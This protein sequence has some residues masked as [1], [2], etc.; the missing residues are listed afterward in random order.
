MT[1]YL[2][3]IAMSLDGRIADR[4][5]GLA[6]LEAFGGGGEGDSDYE[7]FYNGVD[8]LVMGRT[9]YDVVAALGAWP[10]PGKR[11]FV[12]TG[13][14]LDAGRDEIVAIPADFPALKRRIESDGHAKV[15][16]VGGGRTQRAALDAGMFDTLR[17]FVMPVIVGGGPLVFADGGL[18]HARLTHHR[19]WPK[20]IVELGYS[21][22]G[23]PAA[24]GGGRGADRR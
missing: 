12:V 18:A 19:V 22:E 16:I 9:T 15:W 5:H 21:F 14:P 2:G 3:Y 6:W 23:T 11:C 24:S 4:E 7:A 1:A 20:G 10:Y 13:R 17:V 8:A